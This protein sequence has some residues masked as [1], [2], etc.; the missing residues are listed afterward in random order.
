M[1]QS[2]FSLILGYEMECEKLVLNKIGCT[3]E[4]L[5][6]WDESQVPIAS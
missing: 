5:R 3:N 4:S 2:C 6:D 1:N